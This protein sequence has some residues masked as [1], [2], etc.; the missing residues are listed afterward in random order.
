MKNKKQSIDRLDISN[1]ANDI[2][3]EN[4]I[5]TLGEICKK[6]KKELQDYGLSLD[7]GI[8]ITRIKF[9]ILKFINNKGE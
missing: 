5:L 2:L 3:K 6:N 8:T 7:I 1:N 4:K 9:E